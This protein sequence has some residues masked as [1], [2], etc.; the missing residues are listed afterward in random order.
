MIEILQSNIKIDC[1]LIDGNG[2]LHN[3]GCGLASHLG[4]LCNIP[5]IGVSKSMFD[6]DGLHKSLVIQNFKQANLKKGE[7]QLLQ[8]KIRGL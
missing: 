7:Y 3:N 4:V 8:G 5:T 6:L 2:I 1:I